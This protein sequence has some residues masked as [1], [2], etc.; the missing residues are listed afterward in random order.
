MNET[1]Q[2]PADPSP[3]LD[4]T[5]VTSQPAL[6]TSNGGIWL[7]MGALFAA[8]SAVPL[9]LLILAPEGRSGGLALAALMLVLALYA[10]ML[11]IRFAVSRRLLRCGCWR[12]ACSRWLQWRCSASGCA[13]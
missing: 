11:V 6:R 4:P 8:A 9:M 12:C 10:A 5:R 2:D 7:V 1:A 3:G 13:C